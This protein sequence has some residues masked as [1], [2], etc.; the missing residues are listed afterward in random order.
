[1]TTPSDNN[2][3]TT[4]TA[5]SQPSNTTKEGNPFSYER[6]TPVP[7]QVAAQAK[8]VAKSRAESTNPI[9]LPASAQQQHLA[10]IK[11]T[12]VQLGKLL[13]E[14]SYS[15]AYEIELK[16]KKEDSSPSEKSKWI[17]KQL[18]PK[19]RANPL[20]F[21]ACASDLV[22]EGQIL[23]LVGK[24][25]PNIL[26]I[27]GWSGASMVDDYLQGNPDNCQ[28]VLEQLTETLED[29]IKR[30]QDQ[31]ASLWYML[32]EETN[33]VEYLDTLKEKEKHTMALAKALEHLH[34]HNVLHRDLK[35]GT[36]SI[37]G[38]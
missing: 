21:A 5:N 29:K 23:H 26:D 15:T 10:T 28:L 2:N 38:W 22:Q 3:G 6:G 7:P 14:G 25:H 1:M 20:M 4:V 11:L 18:S 17:I 31:S 19:V 8:E 12:D 13:G 16:S 24:S 34:R 36:N 30:W 9:R 33:T 27:H 35:P 32:Y 37:M